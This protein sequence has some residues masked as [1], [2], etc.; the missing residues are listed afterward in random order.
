MRIIVD[1]LSHP[2]VAALLSEHLAGMYA[3]SP[4]E[5]VFALDLN[6]L[7]ATAITFL[8]AWDGEELLGCGAFKQLDAQHAEVKSMRTSSRHLRKGVAQAILVEIM[9]RA[10]ERGIRRLSLETGTTPDFDPAHHLYRLH[11][12][13]ECAPFADY[14]ENDFS[15]FMSKA[16]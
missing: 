4:A 1:D 14:R 6:A 15:L 12:F 3:S 8:T 5:C 13:T 10:S 9:R 7:K 11:G 16:L 2:K